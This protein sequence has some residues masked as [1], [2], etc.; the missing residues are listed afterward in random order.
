MAKRKYGIPNPKRV[1]AG[2]LNQLKRKGFTPEGL[3]RLRESTLRNKPWQYS[4]GPKTPEGKAR[5]AQNG[6]Y[7]QT[8]SIPRE[9]RRREMAEIGDVVA[10]LVSARQLALR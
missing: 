9:Q 6:R 1:S 4:T 8:C 7:N 2:R 3:Q 10:G 5:S